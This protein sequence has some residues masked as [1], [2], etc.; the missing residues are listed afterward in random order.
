MVSLFLITRPHT[1]TSCIWH[2]TTFTVRSFL[3][4]KTFIIRA[5][6]LSVIR[7]KGVLTITIAVII[8]SFTLLIFNTLFIIFLLILHT[9]K[10]DHLRTWALRRVQPQHRGFR[11]HFLGEVARRF[12]DKLPQSD[13]VH[14]L[15]NFELRWVY[16]KF[17]NVFKNSSLICLVNSSA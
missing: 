4:P 1:F 3:T 10:G 8:Q 17:P 12:M 2:A 7:R 6:S 16:C 11:I 9:Q 13:F 14:H 5:A 15:K